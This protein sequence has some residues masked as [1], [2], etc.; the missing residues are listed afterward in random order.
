MKNLFFYSNYCKYS[1]LLIKI[2]ENENMDDKFKYICIDNNNTIPEQIYRVPTLVV[3][4]IDVP[5]QGKNAFEW[6]KI[7]SRT[8]RVTDVKNTHSSN[9]SVETAS[10]SK[11]P[12]SLNQKYTCNSLS[13][14]Y[15]HDSLTQLDQ[16]AQM[17]QLQLM[18][19]KRKQQDYLFQSR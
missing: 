11:K 9:S 8:T 13:R 1:L 10:I 5:L 14:L 2:I 17:H 3:H 12:L 16:E 4:D 15:G 6:V 7:A 19:K 18:Q